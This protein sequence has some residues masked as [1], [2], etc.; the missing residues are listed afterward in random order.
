MK[1]EI[2]IEDAEAARWMEA[3]AQALQKA[4]TAKTPKPRKQK[5]EDIIEN[6]S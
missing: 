4:P 1:I 2:T 5:Q 6:I 3:I